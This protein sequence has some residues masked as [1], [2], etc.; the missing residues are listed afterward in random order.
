[1]FSLWKTGRFC[2]R[3]L[4][5]SVRGKDC[6]DCNKFNTFQA[7]YKNGVQ[8]NIVR[9]NDDICNAMRTIMDLPLKMGKYPLLLMS[10]LVRNTSFSCIDTNANS[11]IIDKKDIR[12]CNKKSILVS[13]K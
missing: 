8:V 5:C 2:E 11:N 13:V 10:L 6:I 9:H 12:K 4:K 1:M 7:V 3:S